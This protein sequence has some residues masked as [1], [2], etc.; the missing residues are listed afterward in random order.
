MSYVLIP[1]DIDISTLTPLENNKLSFFNAVKE[2]MAGNILIIK[3]FE[4]TEGV[5]TYVKVALELNE[6]VTEITY[7]NPSKASTAWQP[8][9]I[10]LNTF[11]IE[12]CYLYDKDSYNFDSI[13]RPGE[14]I[15]YSDMDNHLVAGVVK[16]VYRDGKGHIYYQFTD[17]KQLYELQQSG[18]GIYTDDTDGKEPFIPVADTNSDATIMI[19]RDNRDAVPAQI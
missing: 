17:S 2:I 3:G 15:K 11:S 18:Q 12:D 4:Q 19:V 9:P 7:T 5:D 1:T 16:A 10:T 13:Y 8:F 14:V 6:P